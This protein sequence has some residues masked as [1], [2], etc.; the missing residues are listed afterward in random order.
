M[1]NT[2]TLKYMTYLLDSGIMC[3]TL[4]IYSTGGTDMLQAHTNGAHPLWAEVIYW[5]TSNEGE[6]SSDSMIIYRHESTQAKKE[7]IVECNV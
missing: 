5:L 4:Y 1:S 3:A 7:W 2:A 6:H